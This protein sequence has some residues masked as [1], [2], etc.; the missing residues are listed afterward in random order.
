MK[1]IGIKL[2][3]K[4][5][6]AMKM[7]VHM[8]QFVIESS[9]ELVL[10]QKTPG[11]QHLKEDGKIKDELQAEIAEV[12]LELTLKLINDTT[13]VLDKLECDDGDDDEDERE[14]YVPAHTNGF[15]PMFG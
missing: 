13:A 12:A 11:P 1:A 7:G 3:Q 6:D 10:D 9:T 4:D 8:L 14:E 2:S 5:V 15:N